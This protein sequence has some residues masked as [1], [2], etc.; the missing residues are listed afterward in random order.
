MCAAEPNLFAA[1]VTNMVQKIKLNGDQ[2]PANAKVVRK[3]A[4]T[5]TL[6]IG[7]SINTTFFRAHY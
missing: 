7:P 3:S 5:M 2:F 1:F 4:E 6:E